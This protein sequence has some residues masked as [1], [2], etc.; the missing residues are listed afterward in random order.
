[1]EIVLDI[2]LKAIRLHVSLHAFMSGKGEGTFMMEIKLAQQLAYIEQ[3]ALYMVFIDLRKAYDTM[4]NGRCLKILEAY[5]VGPNIRRLLNYFREEAELVCRASGRYGA[6]FK[7]H[8][9]VTQCWPISSRIFNMMVDV[10]V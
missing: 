8:Q 7:A 3:E 1:M 10:V 6:L 5:G 2:W 9:G 4:D